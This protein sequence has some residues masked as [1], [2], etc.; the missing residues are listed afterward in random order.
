MYCYMKELVWS[1]A[2]IFSIWEIPRKTY[3]IWNA[4]CYR[5]FW[6]RKKNNFFPKFPF[7]FQRNN[8]Y[9][10]LFLINKYKKGAHNQAKYW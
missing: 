10:K 6:D 7:I 4:M 3:Q 9:T 5:A 8:L 1:E 2:A